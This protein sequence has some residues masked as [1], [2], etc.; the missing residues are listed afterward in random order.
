MLFDSALEHELDASIGIVADYHKSVL[1]FYKGIQGRGFSLSFVIY[2]DT[3]QN[4]VDNNNLR[5]SS[6]LST[7]FAMSQLLQFLNCPVFGEMSS[8]DI[9]A[10][11]VSMFKF[12]HM[13]DPNLKAL[14]LFTLTRYCLNA[15]T[16]QITAAL[17]LVTA[18]LIVF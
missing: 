11:L 17:S 1:Q 12:N 14:N 13:Q 15:K 18:Q 16:D 4:F 9:I 6:Y 10:K 5:I 2:T 8:V 3:E 7:K